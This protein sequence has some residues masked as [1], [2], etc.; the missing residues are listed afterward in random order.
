MQHTNRG[1]YVPE[2]IMLQIALYNRNW[3]SG[4]CVNILPSIN[5]TAAPFYDTVEYMYETGR[6]IYPTVQLWHIH[7]K[8]SFYALNFSFFWQ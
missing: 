6:S 4:F 1:Y 3:T 7:E 2:L 8:S 5:C